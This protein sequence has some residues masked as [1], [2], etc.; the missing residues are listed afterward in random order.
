MNDAISVSESHGYNS[1]VVTVLWLW[2]NN[3]AQDYSE[4][5]VGVGAQ[6]IC[7][8]M[9]ELAWV[10]SEAG[11]GEIRGRSSIKRVEE[12]GLMHNDRLILLHCHRYC[13]PMRDAVLQ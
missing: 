5:R 11:V 10:G 1:S 4:P 2:C 9:R 7:V 8:G 12:A 13:L 3:L 6:K